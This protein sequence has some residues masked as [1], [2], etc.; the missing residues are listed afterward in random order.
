MVHSPVHSRQ[1]TGLPTDCLSVRHRHESHPLAS[2]N[3]VKTRLSF[4]SQVS[5]N[6][7]SVRLSVRL[8]RATSLASPPRSLHRTL[9]RTLRGILPADHQSSVLN[10]YRR[11]CLQL[12]PLL[13]QVGR[14]SSL[15]RFGPDLV[16]AHA[17]RSQIERVRHPEPSSQ[18]DTQP[19]SLRIHPSSPHPRR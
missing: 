15:D 12:G 2:R 6:R 16:D 5:L 9:R 18:P 19:S 10:D 17:G 11:A 7:Q 3:P 8:S 1:R 13:R 4:L 14:E